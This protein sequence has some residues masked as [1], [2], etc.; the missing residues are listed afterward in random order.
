MPS[1]ADLIERLGALSLPPGLQKGLLQKLTTAQQNPAQACN[2]L[3]AFMSQVAGADSRGKI[4]GADADQLI[5][6]AVAVR[7]LLGCDAALGACAGREATI[8]GTGRSDRLR[9]TNGDDVIAA[10]GGDDRV[11][12]LGGDDLICASGGADVIEGARGDDTLRGGRGQDEL[13]GGGGSD[14]CR[15]G[16]G[17]DSKHRC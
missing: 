1:I 9:G 11:V 7:E 10:G 14:K 16:G 17:P 12:G 4:P 13:R 2:E 8:V 3:A 5:A 15:G 6:E